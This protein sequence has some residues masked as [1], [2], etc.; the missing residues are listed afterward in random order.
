LAF[1]ALVE[2]IVVATIETDAA[3]IFGFDGVRLYNIAALEDINTI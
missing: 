1:Q 2:T 3:T